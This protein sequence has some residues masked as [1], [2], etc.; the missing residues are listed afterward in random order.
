MSVAHQVQ[1][2]AV[3][4]TELISDEEGLCSADQK[5]TDQNAKY[6]YPN[7]F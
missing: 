3:S 5:E 7:I 1:R 4:A 2:F 6:K